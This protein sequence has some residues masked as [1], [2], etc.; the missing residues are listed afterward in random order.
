MII[1][2]CTDLFGPVD[3][4][5]ALSEAAPVDFVWPGSCI[6]SHV[7][8]FY[9]NLQTWP[10]TFACW[11]ICWSLKRPAGSTG[12]V[13]IRLITCDDGPTNIAEIARISSK[14]W[15][16]GTNVLNSPVDITAALNS[17]ITSKTFKNVGWQIQGDGL[18]IATFL[19]VRLELYWQVAG[20]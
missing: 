5:A 13:N 16:A 17:L 15:P 8:P 6:T 12:R 9:F 14:N 11:R 19:S 1:P 10:L 20:K 3:G 2:T 18:A 4:A 7:F